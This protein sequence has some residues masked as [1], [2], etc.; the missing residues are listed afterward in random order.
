VQLEADIHDSVLSD[1]WRTLAIGKSGHPALESLNGPHC[2]KPKVELTSARCRA[3]R[4]G[5]WHQA[6]P[7]CGL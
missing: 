6:H 2:L 1:P 3:T 4:C 5:N 7:S